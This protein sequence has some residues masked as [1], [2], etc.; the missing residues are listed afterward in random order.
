M[1]TIIGIIGASLIL[2][3]F[4]A[5]QLGHW[6]TDSKKYDSVNAL[7][8]LFLMIYSYLISSY[9]FLILNT[10]WF[11]VAFRDVIKK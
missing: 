11:L 5:N 3:A 1:D 2:I 4:T 10:I 6:K 7:G 9:P 8:A